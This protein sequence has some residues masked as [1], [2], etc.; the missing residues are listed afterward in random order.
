MSALPLLMDEKTAALRLGLS[1][2]TLQAWRVTGGG[3]IYRKVGR[4][5]RYAESDLAAFVEA[6]ARRHTSE[7]A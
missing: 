7:G 3:P 4:Q 1:H 5:V 6:G 2:R